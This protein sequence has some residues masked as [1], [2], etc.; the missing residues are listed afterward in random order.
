MRILNKSLFVAKCAPAP[1]AIAAFCL[2]GISSAHAQGSDDNDSGHPIYVQVDMGLSP[3]T[4]TTFEGAPTGG[5]H[6]DGS[7]F[8][9]SLTI[10]LK[11]ASWQTDMGGWA[12]ELSAYHRDLATDRLTIGSTSQASD[13]RVR[14]GGLMAN[15]RYEMAVGGGIRPYLTGGMGLACAKITDTPAL[16]LKDE[17]SKD[18][19]FAAHFGAGVGFQP[20][21]L[22]R[23][24]LW[25]GYDVLTVQ[26]PR[27][28]TEFGIAPT[29][30]IRVKHV[31]PQTVTL[32][33]R[34]AF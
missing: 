10:G 13:G 8:P 28:E 22:G 23:A 3:K 30:S 15:V 27:F 1:L 24:S 16:K 6:H 17:K 18:A 5:M 25:L 20:K 34:Y 2:L 19:K 14:I 33:A 11:P 32:G 31:L 12:I 9:A 4:H 21:A 29:G 7:V 26:S